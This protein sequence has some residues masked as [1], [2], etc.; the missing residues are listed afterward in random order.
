MEINLDKRVQLL[1]K[2]I[3]QPM[4]VIYS[5]LFEG[6]TTRQ[7]PQITSFLVRLFGF[8]YFFGLFQLFKNLEKE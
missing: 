2:T 5:A 7:L 3:T 6:D 8:F 4:D 1:S